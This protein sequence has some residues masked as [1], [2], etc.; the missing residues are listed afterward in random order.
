[1]K[2]QK[3]MLAL[4]MSALLMCSAAACG[5]NSSSTGPIVEPKTE[6]RSESRSESKK[7]SSKKS[8]TES[9]SES[10]DS[11]AEE[12]S[13]RESST[14]ESSKKESS[15]EELS[16]GKV[17]W[18]N[19]D[20][21]ADDILQKLAKLYTDRTGVTVK[22]VSSASGMYEETL[23]VEMAKSEAPTLFILGPANNYVSSMDADVWGEYALDLKDTDVFR[24]LNSDAFTVYI[25]DKAASIGYRYECYG[26]I[27]NP[28]LVAKAGYD[29]ED[30]KNFSS[31]K[32]VV[33]G[34]HAK[35][36]DLGFDAFTSCDMDDSSSWKFTGHMTNL[37]YFYE[38]RDS[39]SR[40]MKTP[41]S[42]TGNYLPNFK[43]LYD[44]CTRNSLSKPSELAVGGHDAD[45][46][47]AEEKAAFT[48]QG[49]WEWDGY[50]DYKSKVPNAKMIPYYCGVDGEEKAG[51]NCGTSECWAVNAKASPADRKATLDFMYWCVTDPDASRMMVDAFGVLP[52]KR[53]AKPA[54][55][56][57][58]NADDYISSGHYV[59]DWATSYQPDI[60]KYREDL[61]A[62][63]N[64]YNANQTDANW[65]GVQTAF[66]DGWA[67]HAKAVKR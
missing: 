35:A 1:M 53:A 48:I 43:N 45:A 28:D 15:S 44:L 8:E 65:K 38:E 57:L 11:S 34:I 49:S 20:P 51:L 21:L 3:Q 25:G 54:N 30:I 42:I 52:Y 33:E 24:E 6:S 22:V 63:L 7:E 5:G 29:P 17:Y 4:L 9:K 47:F 18:L 41:D 56:F 60:D 27:M 14:E 12:S 50:Y 31:L 40:W 46:Q 62:A 61:V 26:I 16:G 13:K 37:E 32:T 55:R 64:K 39:G 2:K 10:T 36:S 66:V 59:M 19:Y 58:A 67:T 23:S